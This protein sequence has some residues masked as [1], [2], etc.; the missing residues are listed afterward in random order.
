MKRILSLLCLLSLAGLCRAQETGRYSF[1]PP[2]DDFKTDALLD[3][4]W[5]NEKTAGATG[6]IR[7]GAEGNFILGDGQPIRF[8]AVGSDVGREKPWQAR[9]LGRGT[10]PDLERHARFLAKRGVNMVRCHAHINPSN[11]ESD[12]NNINAAE[13]D[14]I[15]RV[16]AAMKKQGIYT[17]LSPYWSVQMKLNAAWGIPAADG[18]DNCLN[19]LFFDEKLQNAYKA[20]MRALLFE[21]NPYTGI[22]LAQDP[23]VAI[24]SLQN[25]DSLL[26]WT[27][28]LLRGNE[29]G[30]VLGK[31]YGDWLKQ[32]HGSLEAARTAWSGTS[33]AGDDLANGIM[34]FYIIWEMTQSPQNQSEGKTK[35]LADQL[36]FWTKTLLE[37]NRSM[38]GYLHDTLGCGQIIN[39]GNW[40]T[41]DTV[42]LEDCERFSY[43]STEV[44]AV[45]RY[46]GGVHK[47]PRNNEGWAIENNDT[48]TSLSILLDPR[49]FPLNL[50]QAKGHPMII[51][52]STW[53]M[54]NG[55]ATE[56]PFLVSAYQSL[57][58]IDA[59]YWFATGDDEW[60][61]P[62][63]A[64]GYMPSQGKW[65]FGNPDMLGNF[66]AASLLFRMGYLKQGEPVVHEVRALQDMWDR[67]TPI[68]AESP[69]FDPNRDAGDIAQGSGVK[70][71]VDPAAFLMG[72]VESSFD[73][74]PAETFK[75][76]LDSLLSPDKKIIKSITGEITLNMAVGS[77]V[78][79][80]PKVQ[81]VA[82]FFKNQGEFQLMD[83]R[84]VSGN[85]YG[86]VL[87]VSMDNR[88]LNQSW[89]ILVQA[90]T[91]S[92]PTGWVEEPAQIRLDNG[93]LV[94]GYKVASYGRAPW[95]VVKPN[96]T[97][98]VN[99]PR[100]AKVTALDLNGN[101]RNRVAFDRTTAGIR[102]RFPE[103]TMYVVLEAS[104]DRPAV[105]RTQTKRVREGERESHQEYK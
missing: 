49:D 4:R 58:G 3:L 102:F 20:W 65:L 8:W 14:W 26:F 99:H 45:N 71:G 9:P 19:L 90:G 18:K 32:K 48:F 15:W 79:D 64:N 100:I 55:F 76:D 61:P 97:V 94:D 74:N 84:I 38:A 12:L 35:R 69:S 93:S 87:V 59:Y 23:A 80:S 78:V 63:S 43:T 101:A 41:A 40:K 53:V 104:T 5:L 10:E 33:L 60:T 81:G 54:P 70:T 27:V 1:D 89:K 42:R 75:A 83:C 37:F 25:E 96:L 28:D 7:I 34:D 17:T 95:A 51:T 21:Q 44:V 92:R 85:E 36:E 24:I 66:P 57:T 22:S 67:R 73:G 68:I 52:E 16:V 72:P 98:E 11:T 2:L 77:C 31:K 105:T 47:S 91:Q 88:P 50:K 6:F 56:G 30:R 86:S 62:Q 29:Q 82:A 13:R 46:F 103:D 39:A